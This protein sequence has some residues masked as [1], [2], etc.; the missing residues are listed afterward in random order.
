MCSIATRQK[1]LSYA[2]S[3]LQ[4]HFMKVELGKVARLLLSAR[5]HSKHHCTSVVYLDSA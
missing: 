4:L 5:S 3:N 1:C 2:I